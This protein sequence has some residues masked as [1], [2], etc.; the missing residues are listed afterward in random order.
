MMQHKLCLLGAT[1]VGKTSLVRQFV[2]GIFDEK[3]L[4]TIG[5]KIDKKQIDL[6]GTKVQF[7]L[8]DI[9]G[10][11]QYATYQQRYIRG[12]SA[13]IIVV[14]KSRSQS[15]IE[16]MNIYTKVREL[17]S[18]PIVLAINKSDLVDTWHWSDKELADYQSVFDLHFM[19]SAKTGQQ[20]E[21]M[22]IELAQ[23]LVAEKT[24]D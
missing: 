20:V 9:E 2:Q 1:G 7:L 17:I 16:G 4:T 14:D 19:T 12:S 6:Q 13:I 15:L 22:F 10:T 18:C 5:V 24:H 21:Q 11:D 23:L 3:Y 8:W